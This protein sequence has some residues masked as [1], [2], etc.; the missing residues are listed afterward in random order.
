MIIHRHEDGSEGY[1][2]HQ[3]DIVFVSKEADKNCGRVGKVYLQEGPDR[4][5]GVAGI[6]S[7]LWVYDLET[8]RAI[9]KYPAWDLNPTEE[10]HN[11]CDE[12]VNCIQGKPI[13]EFFLNTL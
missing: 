6:I 8:K 3:G 5:A 1:L 13:D 10:T 12:I 7:F 2:Y 11:N 9:G 4:K